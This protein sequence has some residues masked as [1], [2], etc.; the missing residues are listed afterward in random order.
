[1]KRIFDLVAGIFFLI[2]IS[3]PMLLISVMIKA[4]S[5]GSIIFKQKR[6]GKNQQ[7]FFIYKFRTMYL[8]T[9]KDIPTHMLESPD[10]FI[11]PLGKILRKTSLDELPQIFNILKGEMSF[12]GPRPAL[13]NQYDLIRLREQNSVN[14]V[15]PGVT[16]WAQINGRD[17]LPISEK[18]MF[19][20]YY[21]QKIS[22]LFDI[23]IIF[24]TFYNVLLAKGIVE[25]K[26]KSEELVNK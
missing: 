8:E 18:V 3:V 23:K 10:K 1:M 13:Y 24:L 4:S 15:L 5:K 2:L 25:G 6:I 7:E 19:D 16:G 9:P 22:I 17:E 14:S 11:T 26:Q 12:V 20:K 21:V